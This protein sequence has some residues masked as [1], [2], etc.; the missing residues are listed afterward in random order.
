M[1]SVTCCECPGARD[2]PRR[3]HAAPQV[4][5]TYTG[6]PRLS[7]VVRKMKPSRLAYVWRRASTPEPCR[8]LLRLPGVAPDPHRSPSACI[9]ALASRVRPGAARSVN[10]ASPEP[11]SV[12][13]YFPDIAFSCFTER[14]ARSGLLVMDTP[15]YAQEGAGGLPRRRGRGCIGR[16]RRGVGA[17]GGGAARGAARLA[18]RGP[19]S[20]VLGTSVLPSILFARGSAAGDRPRVTESDMRAARSTWRRSTTTC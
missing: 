11:I 6:S 4:S 15:R 10:P 8:F 14:A 17:P 9:L 3:P 13:I 19:A 7:G 16:R 1:P 20:D 2:R 12:T 18:L 5:A